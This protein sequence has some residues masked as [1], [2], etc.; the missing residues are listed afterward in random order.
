ML[1]TISAV[2]LQCRRYYDNPYHSTGERATDAEILSWYINQEAEVLAREQEL[3]AEAIEAVKRLP[4]KPEHVREAAIMFYLEDLMGEEIAGEL[5]L[6]PGTVR[7]KLS[8][9]RK[10][11]REAFEVDDKD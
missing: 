11:L 5:D 6:P 1:L 8:E 2:L 7:R 9:A 10:L 4:N 3:I